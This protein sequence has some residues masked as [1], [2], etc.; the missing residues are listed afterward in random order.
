MSDLHSSRK[1]TLDLFLAI[2]SLI[3][4]YHF[5]NFGFLGLGESY[6]IELFTVWGG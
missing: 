5:C 4:L 3:T 6:D 2:I 1:R